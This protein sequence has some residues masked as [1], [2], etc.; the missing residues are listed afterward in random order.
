MR[1]THLGHACTLVEIGD[2]RIVIDPGAFSDRWHGVTDLD[3]ILV[4]HA[5]PDHLDQEHVPALVALN[6]Q[7]VVCTDP[8]S[9]AAL[10]DLGVSAEEHDGSSFEVAGVT[11]TPV[12]ET[13]ALIHDDIPRIP[14]VGVRLDVPGEP[15]FYHP[16]DALDGEPGEV[17]VLAFPLNAPW[18][19]SRFMT[20]FLRR[21]DPPVAVPIHDG[22]LNER[23]RALYLRQADTLGGRH[24]M[25]EDLADGLAHQFSAPGA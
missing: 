23:G 1:L 21:L 19:A 6:P 24:T 15:S 2:A 12:G 4:T 11:V 14:N 10:T 13:H 18:A 25:I 16:G 3:A 8:G 20:G 17:D 9:R 22:L 7:A 5:H